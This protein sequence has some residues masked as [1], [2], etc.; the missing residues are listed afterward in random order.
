[1]NIICTEMEETMDL[2]LS[3]AT[4]PADV[5]SSRRKLFIPIYQ[6]LFVWGEEQIDNLLCDL[7]EA[8]KTGKQYY[9]GVITVHENEERQ[10]EIVD[11]QQ[12]LTFLTLLGSVFMKKRLC[13]DVNWRDFVLLD[14]QKLR[15]Y[16][17]GRKNDREDIL[18]FLL[19]DSQAS[20]VN[21]PFECFLERV[22]RFTNGKSEEELKL[23]SQYCFSNA[24]FLVNEL[25]SAYGPIELNLYFERMNSTGRQLSPIEVV[26]GRWFSK[27][28]ARWN[29]CM[30]FDHKLSVSTSDSCT[31]VS[32][33]MLSLSDVISETEQAR[34]DEAE[35][36]PNPRLSHK[37]VMRDDVLAL[38]VLRKILGKG[39]S[40]DHSKLIDTFKAN[41]SSLDCA[42]F[43]EELEKYRR[44]LDENIIYLR[45]DGGEFD[46]VFRYDDEKGDSEDGESDEAA[47]K[48]MIRQFQSML[49]VSSDER[50]QWVLDAYVELKGTTLK[51]EV[52][53]RMENMWHKDEPI[54]EDNSVMGY[55]HISRY[56][57]WKLDYLLWEQHRLWNQRRTDRANALFSD[58]ANKLFCNLTD[59]E[60][61]AIN[62]YVFKANRSIEHFHPQSKESEKW[63]ERGNPQAAMH[64]FGNLAMISPG[65]NSAQSD[66]PIETKVGRAK[67]WLVEG[68]GVESIKM[69]LMCK[70]NETSTWK[71]ELSQE[72]CKNMV[73]LLRQDREYWLARF[74]AQSQEDF[75]SACD[76]NKE[77]LSPDYSRESA[78]RYVV[79]AIDSRLQTLG[80]SRGGT[81]LTDASLNETAAP[82]YEKDGVK[83]IFSSEANNCSEMFVGILN[84][85]VGGWN[86][87]ASIKAKLPHWEQYW[88]WCWHRLSKGHLNWNNK[89]LESCKRNQAILDALK[90]EVA[91]LI[92]E[93]YTVTKQVTG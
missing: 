5:V 84:K 8:Q 28:A 21:R 81:E 23:F 18:K 82:Y 48:K 27:Y 74:S 42:G 56:W 43:I 41:V 32:T 19:D 39:I 80:F 4:T 13:G 50:Q 72:H 35:D 59:D 3:S 86:A 62:C 83:I 58:L 89:F 64:G 92:Q 46:Y 26:K 33:S 38:H 73:T 75:T 85:Y 34:G 16:F 31:E 17:H 79:N 65:R 93:A 61:K 88:V 78:I 68:R 60:K 53:R 11:G 70:L 40:L 67:S 30:N 52:L 15:L 54:T 36:D 10:W 22:T 14:E 49:Y 6:R 63:G 87:L 57:F 20:F 12:R 45:N 69:L 71:V 66:D 29:A 37:L 91:S 51:Y 1:M 76:P 77:I 2:N 25:P 9:L 7:W 24:A 55:Y 44:W 90:N 47:D